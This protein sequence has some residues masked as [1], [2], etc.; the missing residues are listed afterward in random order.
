M[1][2]EYIMKIYDETASEEV[3][4]SELISAFSDALFSSGCDGAAVT[5]EDTSSVFAAEASAR[6]D[7]AAELPELFSGGAAEDT[8]GFSSLFCSADV[9]PGDDAALTFYPLSFEAKISLGSVSAFLTADGVSLFDE[10]PFVKAS[11]AI[12]P[13]KIKITASLI[14]LSMIHLSEF[15][16]FY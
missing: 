14:F 6:F 12:K 8:G 7:G 10:Q 11:A 5:S 13:S 9:T 3:C 16:H 2:S 15:I 4:V 1:L